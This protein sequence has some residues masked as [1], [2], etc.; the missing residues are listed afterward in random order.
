MQDRQVYGVD[1]NAIAISHL[2]KLPK[3]SGTTP[4]G[5]AYKENSSLVEDEESNQARNHCH[6]R[7]ISVQFQGPQTASA[8]T[9]TT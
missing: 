4:L 3:L 2:N 9:V 8:T 7:R 1:A 5:S 6:A